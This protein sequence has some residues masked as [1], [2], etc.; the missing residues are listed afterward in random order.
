M[1]GRTRFW[2]GSSNC[3][4]AAVGLRV[5][6]QEHTVLPTP[7]LPC[8]HISF[9]LIY[10]SPSFTHLLLLIHSFFCYISLLLP[11]SHSLASLSLSSCS[12]TVE[13]LTMRDV[14]HSPSRRISEISERR[15]REG[16]DPFPPNTHRH[17]MWPETSC[18]TM[19]PC[20][21]VFAVA[22]TKFLFTRTNTSYS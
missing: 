9:S 19:C 17:Q 13:S 11:H 18:H 16:K 3:S 6:R 20:V 1:G 4:S 15:R 21:C 12:Q 5:Y 14:A 10:L 2:G 22:H 7:S 8:F